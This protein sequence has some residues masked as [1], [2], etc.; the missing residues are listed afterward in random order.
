M[1]G[2]IASAVISIVKDIKFKYQRRICTNCGYE[3]K[4]IFKT[5]GSIL[6][7]IVLWLLFIVLGLI[8]SL[9]RSTTRKMMISSGCD[10]LNTM[11]PNNSLRAI[12]K[13]NSDTIKY[14]F[15]AENNQPEAILCRFYSKEIN[16][17]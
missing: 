14:P 11:I 6:I 4:A 8:Y 1:I 16:V 3:G 7:E 9:W 12:T 13:I 5:K 10:N 2:L 15:C 17:A